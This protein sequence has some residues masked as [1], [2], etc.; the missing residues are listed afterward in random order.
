MIDPHPRPDVP[1]SP[2]GSRTRTVAT[3]VPRLTQH[4]EGVGEPTAANAPRQ[5][6][7]TARLSQP[8]A[9]AV[10]RQLA[11]KHG[12]CCSSDRAAPYRQGHRSDGNLEVPCGGPAS[13]KRKPCVPDR[14][15]S[16]ARTSRRG[17]RPEPVVHPPRTVAGG[18]QGPVGAA[19]TAS[20]TTTA[21]GS[22]RLRTHRAT[23]AAITLTATT[24]PLIAFGVPSPRAL[25]MTSPP[26][27]RSP[28][29]HL[30]RSAPVGAS[31]AE[32]A[33]DRTSLMCQSET[34]A[35]AVGGS[36]DQVRTPWSCE[37][38]AVR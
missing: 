14:G 34:P 36:I 10:L 22:G 24:K 23:P 30:G 16:P 25:T 9:G 17:P 29:S 28:K 19:D 13:S 1:G 27:W 7:R 3:V 15:L 20:R 12:V 32:P 33:A 21:S 37:P 35:G 11:E 2:L 6:S 18:A 8:I 5:G 38:V 31:R 26:S 4:P